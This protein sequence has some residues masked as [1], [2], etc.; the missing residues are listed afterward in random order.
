MQLSHAERMAASEQSSIRR[1]FDMA[2]AA[3]HD[4]VR[5]EVGQPDFST[6]EHVIDAADRAA[7]E[8]HT[9]YTANA[10]IEP[11]REAVATTLE[12]EYG[13][14]ATPDGVA[15]T[16]GGMEALHLAM[17]GL[18]DPGD[19][20]LLPSPVWPNYRT[21]TTLAG[22]TP[23]EIPLS[24]DDGYALDADAVIEQLDDSTAAIVLCT[25]SN[26]TGRVFE[27]SAVR[28]VVDA[29]GA[30]DAA[31][32]ADEV[33]LGLTYDREP[34]GI[35]SY[36]DDASRVL[37]VGSVSKTHSMTGWRVGW[38]AGDPSFIDGVNTIHESTSS[39]ASSISQRAAL[40]ALTGP[41]APV[42]EMRDTFARRRDFVVDRIESIDGL[43]A[44][45]PQG[46]FYAFLSIDVPGTAT[47]IATRLLQEFGVV[48]APGD[49]FGTAGEGHLRLS[50]ANST[51]QLE[52]GFDRLETAI[53]TW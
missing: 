27:E 18:V 13:V 42:K 37:T 30:H 8:G 45:R 11:L 9:G 12:T 16:A 19:R 52:A 10:G 38:L 48:L 33:Y 39:C 36:V 50:F 49:G 34:R 5:L 28:A 31:V 53:E 25:P 41:E 23:V 7:R 4:L 6:P 3:D 47:E 22:G 51:E 35:A 24:A 15:I 43:S 2:Q 29:A 20:V 32:I 26:P 46:A 44:P 40:A 1:M 21:Q 17:L 14:P